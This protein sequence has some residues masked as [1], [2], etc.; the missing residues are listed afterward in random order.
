[1]MSTLLM[2]V[3]AAGPVT[4]AVKAVDAPSFAP[5]QVSAWLEHVTSLMEKGGRLR[6]VADGAPANGTLQLSIAR[7]DALL[8]SLEIRRVDGSKWVGTHGSVAAEDKVDDWLDLAAVEVEAGLV[9]AALAQRRAEETRW[10]RW[11]PG[12]F[13]VL[14]GG[15]AAVCLV[16]STSRAV[17]LRK[18][19]QLDASSITMLA[20]E[21]RTLELAGLV[22][23]GVAGVGLASSIVWLGLPSKASFALAPTPGGVTFAFGAAF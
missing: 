1:M 7:S 13:G 17:Q 19:T 9:G 11:M 3:L 15:G 4:L 18:A 20:S 5:A 6:L 10:L 14:S 12:V 23:A 8:L 21:G 22:L 16:L 2:S